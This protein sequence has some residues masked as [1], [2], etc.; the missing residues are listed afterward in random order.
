MTEPDPYAKP[1]GGY[2]SIWAIP[3]DEPDPWCHHLLIRAA[4]AMLEAGKIPEANV[5]KILDDDSLR[6]IIAYY[7]GYNVKFKPGDRC[8]A[9]GETARPEWNNTLPRTA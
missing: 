4:Y 7:G 9:C 8:P 2:V 1:E 3:K 5:L 6:E